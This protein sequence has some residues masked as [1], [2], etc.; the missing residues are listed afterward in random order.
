AFIARGKGVVISGADP[1]YENLQKPGNWQLEQGDVYSTNPGYMTRYVAADGQRLY[2]Y[3]TKGEFEEFICGEPGGW[4]QDEATGRLYVRLSSGENLNSHVMQVACLD[5]G[6]HLKEADH[7]LIDGF[8]IRDYGSRTTGAGIHLDG[9]A[10]CVLRNC[11]IHGMNSKVLLTGGVHAEGNLVEDCELWDTSIPLWPWAM[12]IGHDESG[13][14]VM[15]TGG[16]GNV[17]RG[18]RMHGLFDGLAPSY[19]DSLWVEAYNCDWDVY[20][21]E[22]YDLRDDA[23]EPEG[24]CINFRFWNNYC[25]DL[26]TGISLAP[27]NVGPAFIMYNV[28]YDENWLSLKYGKFRSEETGKGLCYFYHNT[29]YSKKP[30]VNTFV[31]SRPLAGQIFRNNIIYATAYA[32]W[33]SKTPLATNDIDYNDWY[34]SD[35]DWFEMWTGTRYKRLFHFSGRDIFFLKDLQEFIGWEMHGLNADPLFIDPESGDLGLKAGSPC[36]DNGVVLPN[37]NDGYYGEAP[38]M[39]AYERG[40]TLRRPFP[41][42]LKPGR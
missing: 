30:K 1:G 25:H 6:I 22:I 27:I 5:T 41:L 40:S 37:I 36:I 29:I 19:W 17:V 35:T 2:H 8:E 24:P 32:F 7:V 3:R 26:F 31:V 10:W 23:V 34:S 15:S 4:Y 42:G 33:T 39:G 28:L 18:C 38:D 13:G 9:S 21:N 16:R 12:T 14:G 20:D 11:S